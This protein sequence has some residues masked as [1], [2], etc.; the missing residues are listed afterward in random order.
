METKNLLISLCLTLIML[1]LFAQSELISKLKYSNH[2]DV[3]KIDL[4]KFAKGVDSIKTDM[5]QKLATTLNK[6][7]DKMYKVD[8]LMHSASDCGPSSELVHIDELSFS[9][10]SISVPGNLTVN[11]KVTLDKDLQAPISATVVM[12]KM[13]FGHWINI[14]C[15][16]DNIGS[17]FYEDV[18]QL[19]P[20]ADQP[21]NTPCPKE[22]SDLDLPCKCPLQKRIYEVKQLQIQ[23]PKPDVNLPLQG[24]YQVNAQLTLKEE[25]IG[26]VDI[27]FTVVQAKK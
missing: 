26:C 18:C 9:P 16:S 10:D 14:P 24:Q 13:F 5:K 20:N 19:L 3:P 27:T 15:T 8:S 2:L 17:C 21:D 23:I 22:L 6:A 1:T 4:S 11:A 25:V 7:S 12:Q